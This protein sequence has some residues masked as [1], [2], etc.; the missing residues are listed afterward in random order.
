VADAVFRL[1]RIVDRA[2]AVCFVDLDRGPFEDHDVLCGL[3]VEHH[4][5][6]RHQVAC[7]P[8]RSTSTEVHAIVDEDTPDRDCVRPP[9]WAHGGEPVGS[10]VRQALPHS[11]ERQQT[12]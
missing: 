4:C 11:V 8:R 10:G 5:G 1:I 9:I 6:V 12:F 3:G 2:L 7:L